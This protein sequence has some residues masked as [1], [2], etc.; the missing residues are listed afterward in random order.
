[1]RVAIIQTVKSDLGFLYKGDIVDVPEDTGRHYLRIG[2]G[3]KIDQEAE[4]RQK[5]V[6]E[7][8]RIKV[9]GENLAKAIMPERQKRKYQ[10]R[11]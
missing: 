5:K 10:R 1:M 3:Q 11:K 9:S 6:I 4:H 2:I 8:E 7:P